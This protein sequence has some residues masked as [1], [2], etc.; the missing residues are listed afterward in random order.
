MSHLTNLTLLQ[1]SALFEDPINNMGWDKVGE[2][3]QDHACGILNRKMK[4]STGCP[5]PM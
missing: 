1:K 2:T 5:E 4:P 3:V